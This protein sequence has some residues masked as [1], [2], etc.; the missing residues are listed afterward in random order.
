[1]IIVNVRNM[2]LILKLIAI[3]KVRNFNCSFIFKRQHS[4]I[5]IHYRKEEVLLLG[6]VHLT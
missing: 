4:R 2:L 6:H 3:T 1:M 5:V